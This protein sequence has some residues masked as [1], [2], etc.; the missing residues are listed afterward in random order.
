[1]WSDG[2]EEFTEAKEDLAIMEK[3]FDELAQDTNAV[4]GE[5][6]GSKWKCCDIFFYT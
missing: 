1:L 2:G 4:G 6:E 3:Y 5:E